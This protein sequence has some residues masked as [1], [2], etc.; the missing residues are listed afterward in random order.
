MHD[1]E[2]NMILD[3]SKIQYVLLISSEEGSVNAFKA[4]RNP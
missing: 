1:F 3:T 4:F 2:I